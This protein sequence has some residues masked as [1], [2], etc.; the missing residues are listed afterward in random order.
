MELLGAGDPR[1][2][3]PYVLMGRLGA[4]G[5]G[6]VYLGRSAG[7][8]TVAVKVVRPGLSQDPGFR[9]RFRREVHA[10]RR[11]S[12]A[13]T[14]PVVD[15]DPQA[16]TPWMATAFVVGVSLHQAVTRHGPLPEGTARTLAAGLAEALVEVHHAQLIHRD[17]KPANVL[18]ALDGP[19]VIDFG[20]SQAAD[21]TA[22]TTGGAVIG[23]APYMSPEQALGHELTAASDVFSLGATLAFATSGRNLFGDGASAAV[24]F[25]VVNTAPDLNAIPASLRE[26]VAACL[27]KD[28]AHRPT[29]RQVIEFVSREGR[30]GPTANWLPPAVAGDVAALRSVLTSLPEPPANDGL[31]LPHPAGDSGRPPADAVPARG[32]RRRTVLLGVGGV[33]LA[34]AGAATA[35]TLSAGHGT[36]GTGGAG[37]GARGGARSGAQAVPSPTAT[38]RPTWSDVREGVLSWKVSPSQAQGD[39]PR[40]VL[41]AGGLVLVVS[42]QHVRALDA[43]G[44]TRWT[45]RAADHGVGFTS[46]DRPQQL[47]AVDNGVLYVGATA[48]PPDVTVPTPAPGMQHGG[49]VLLA[50][51]LAGGTVR[52]STACDQ[53]NLLGAFRLIGVAGNR[54]QLVGLGDGQLH[55]GPIAAGSSTNVWAVDLSSRRGA[56]FH[57]DSET[58]VFEAL[59]QGGDHSVVASGGH[60][61]ALD[62]NGRVLWTKNRATSVVAAIGGSFLLADQNGVPVAVDPST[63]DQVWSAPGPL[64]PSIDNDAIAVSPDGGT[65][66]GLW[67]DQ[68][69]GQ[70]LA[71]LDSTT[72]H[73]RWRTPLPALAPDTR[74]TAGARLLQADGNLYWMADDAVVWALD[75][76]AGTPRWRF[77]G[78]K[79]TDPAGLGWAAGDSRLCVVDPNGMAVA[80]LPSNGV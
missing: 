17:L 16:E 35:V 77:S 5:M 62:A 37:S 7:G 30:T 48:W 55:P 50:I 64:R 75:P 61:V 8:R 46:T 28:P 69:G 15:A 42:F 56:W 67:K 70:S 24:L 79:G 1:R 71:A 58:L 73:D 32:P 49:L 53:Q 72:G 40:Q 51:D 21:G 31:T 33:V 45:V 29:P 22:L 63:G 25:R 41:A 4:G 2:I 52:W 38:T 19:H 39:G 43:Q 80:V 78:F 10:A 9:D 76:A 20:I 11:V 14:A 27:A 3:G 57:G 54:A 23:S 26:L 44:N 68:D 13:F 12:G 65:F 18:L 6:A 66:Y 34:A 60:C 36:A 74:N 47:A 59:Q